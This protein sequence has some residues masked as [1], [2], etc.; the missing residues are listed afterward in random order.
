MMVNPR[1]AYLFEQQ[2][3]LDFMRTDEKP[4]SLQNGWKNPQLTKVGLY[5]PFGPCQIRL[6]KDRLNGLL[7]A[8]PDVF[9]ALSLHTVYQE[10]PI[11]ATC[12]SLDQVEFE[13]SSL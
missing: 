10:P 13:I 2:Q 7:E 3:K 8:L 11:A 1:P 4:I 9:R 12:G 6:L 5:F